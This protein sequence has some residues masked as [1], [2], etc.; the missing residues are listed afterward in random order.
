MHG[1]D[2]GELTRILCGM[3]IR[4]APLRPKPQHN[5][6]DSVA[7]RFGLILVFYP[8]PVFLCALFGFVLAVFVVFLILNLV[9][10]ILLLGVMI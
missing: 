7:A 9:G 5:K 4:F 8:V 10:Q 1:C 3:K 6:S 2:T